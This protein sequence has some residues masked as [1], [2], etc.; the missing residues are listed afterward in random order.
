MAAKSMVGSG[1]IQ[2]I[3]PLGPA[4]YPSRLAATRYRTCRI[5]QRSL[6]RLRT[7]PAEVVRRIKRATPGPWMPEVSA[8]AGGHPL[9]DETYHHTIR[10]RR[11]RESVP[12]PDQVEDPGEIFP[13]PARFK[14]LRR[15]GWR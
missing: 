1:T 3:S 8:L 2:S 7:E 13:D 4:M 14:F 12:G 5:G 11:N 9:P 15:C 10:A 6:R